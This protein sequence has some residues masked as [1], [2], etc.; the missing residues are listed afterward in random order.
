MEWMMN[1]LQHIGDA[2]WQLLTQPYYYLGIAFVIL[3]Y[4]RQI[5][6]ERRLLNTKL[7]AFSSMLWRNVFWGLAAG[8][9]ISVLLLS[10]GI[11]IHYETIIIIWISALLLALIRARFFCFAYAIGFVGLL[12]GL[13]VVIPIESSNDIVSELLAMLQNIHLP[14]LFVILAI[15]HLLESF[16]MRTAAVRT[17]SPFVTKGKRGYMIGGYRLDGFWIA[18]LFLIVPVSTS[19]L[20][21][22]ALYERVLLFFGEQSPL[23]GQVNMFNS[24]AHSFSL[25]VFPVMFGY[26]VFTTA[27][28]PKNKARWTSSYILLYSALVL[29]LAYFVTLWPSLAIVAALLSIILHE[30]IAWLSAKRENE[31]SPLYTHDEQGLLILGIIAG[32]SAEQMGIVAGEKIRQV[33]GKRVTNRAELHEAFK[34]N[35]AFSKM[36]IINLDGHSKFVQRAIYAGEHHLLGI[37]LA[38]DN[39]SREYTSTRSRSLLS[40][41]S[42]R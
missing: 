6:L 25:I 21:D 20:T 22:V 8:F 3:L 7:H 24:S 12:H 38:P 36:E 18:P 16:L 2:V 1:G 29:A 14:T 19:P 26:S 32:S 28:L 35:P 42:L 10:F 37:I 11:T 41:I 40:Y 4:R 31:H 13:S 27:F 5:Y 17:A 33:N 23:W 30:A 39:Q 15:A 9:I 34:I